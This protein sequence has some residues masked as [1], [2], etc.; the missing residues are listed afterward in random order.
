MLKRSQRG[1]DVSQWPS[2]AIIFSTWIALHRNNGPTVTETFKKNAAIFE[3]QA[4]NYSFAVGE[5]SVFA[6][7]DAKD[8]IS[9]QEA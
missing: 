2:A 8:G 6:Y 5:F 3:T 1:E 9:M 7:K 4:P